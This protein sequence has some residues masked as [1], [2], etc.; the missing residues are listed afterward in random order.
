E[1][2]AAFRAANKQFPFSFT[3]QP[4]ALFA[5]LSLPLF[6]G[7]Q[8]EQDVQVAQAQRDDA[9]YNTRKGQL[10]LQT[11]VTTAYLTL[12]T[13]ARAV[14]LQ[15]QTEQRAKEELRLAEERFRVG[16]GTSLDV[17]QATTSYERAATD[18]ITAIYDFH[19][20]FAVLESAVGRPLR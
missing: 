14:A 19:K 1:Q 12:R 8:R 17:T 10:R 15:E 13:A 9:L 2:A 20:A 3:K 6:N 4:L 5:Q 11:D 16:A 18:H 7:F